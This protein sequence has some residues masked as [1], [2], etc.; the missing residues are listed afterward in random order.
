[1][2]RRLSLWVL[3]ALLRCLPF[4]FSCSSLPA[5]SPCSGDKV[6][7]RLDA[8]TLQRYNATPCQHISGTA[9][10]TGLALSNG[11]G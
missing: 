6:G 3:G 4:C 5:L 8:E 10:R 7:L 2:E 9:Y 1:M 11:L